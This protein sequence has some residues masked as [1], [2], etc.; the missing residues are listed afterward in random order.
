MDEEEYKDEPLTVNQFEF[1][2]FKSNSTADESLMS[3][4][5]FPSDASKEISP[6]SGEEKTHDEKPIE[7]KLN[8]INDSIKL[9]FLNLCIINLNS[10]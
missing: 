1:N 8:I 10:L 9:V 4:S 6:P 5:M 7:T 2:P 3:S